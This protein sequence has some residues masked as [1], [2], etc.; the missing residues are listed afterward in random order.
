MIIPRAFRREQHVVEVRMDV[1]E[2]MEELVDF[3]LEKSGG[4]MIRPSV[5]GVFAP[6]QDDCT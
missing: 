4:R 3:L 1:L 6:G 5:I 2:S